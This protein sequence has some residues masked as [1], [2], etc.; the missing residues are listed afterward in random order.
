MLFRST[1][2]ALAV[3]RREL[4]PRD[5]LYTQPTLAWTGSQYGLTWARVGS[6]GADVFFRRLDDKGQ[7]VGDPLKFTGGALG[8]FPT[9][10]WNGTEFAV[11]WT[12][13][14]ARGFQLRFGR[15]D[16]NGRRVGGDAVLAGE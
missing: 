4:T 7:N 10:T 13:L 1:P 8:I 16:A 9:L 11:A 2:D 15:I 12:H 14:G 3:P 6:D 5:A